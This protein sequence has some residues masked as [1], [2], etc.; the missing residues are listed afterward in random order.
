MATTVGSASAAARARA[1][2]RQLSSTVASTAVPSRDLNRYLASQ[3]WREMG[4]MPSMAEGSASVLMC[5]S[6]ASS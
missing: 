5:M 6:M 1:T 3:I 2:R 4:A